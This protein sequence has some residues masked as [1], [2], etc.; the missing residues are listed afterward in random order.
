ML[1]CL[2][3][4]S[5]EPRII[6]VFPSLPSIW[7]LCGGCPGSIKTGLEASE[8][9]NKKKKKNRYKKLREKIQ[10]LRQT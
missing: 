9:E 1:R 6:P 2:S 10:A 7:S 8:T 5:P 4:N 3:R